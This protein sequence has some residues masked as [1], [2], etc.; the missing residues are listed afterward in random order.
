VRAGLVEEDGSF[1]V[2]TVDDPVPGAGD[3]I[4][5]VTGC[6][7]CGSDLKSR[8]AMAPGTVMGHEYAGEVVAAGP[9]TE[10]W[11]V[12]TRAAV[13]PVLSCGTCERCR[14]GDVAHCPSVTLVGLGGA[15]GGP[16]SSRSPSG[17]TPPA[18]GRSPPATT[19]WWSAVA[20]SASPPP[21]GR[22]SSVRGA[23]RCRTRRRPGARTVG[24]DQLD[25][26][27]RSLTGPTGDVKIVVD[28]TLRSG[29]A[30]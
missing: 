12:G 16:W 21:A 1:T 4:V 28:P 7:I 23:S 29:T 17:S 14:A 30:T 11:E 3:L 27:F 15:P 9:A 19:C 25:E 2:A 22:K 10:G 13:L 6:G 5:R 18:P 20:R 26:A 8:P 24:L